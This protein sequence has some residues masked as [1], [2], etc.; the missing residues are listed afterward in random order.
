MWHFLVELG[1]PMTAELSTLL[2]CDGGTKERDV[3]NL[4]L[5]GDRPML[6]CRVI[7]DF[8]EN[9]KSDL[10]LLYLFGNGI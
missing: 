7:C 6:P 5:K 8:F 3:L 4:R 1:G 10:G 2:S 9:Q